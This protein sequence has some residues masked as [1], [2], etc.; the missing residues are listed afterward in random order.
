MDAEILKEK[1]KNKETIYV[2]DGGGT[3][4]IPLTEGV[5]VGQELYVKFCKHS[6]CFKLSNVFDS[7]EEAEEHIKFGNITREDS[8]KLPTWKEINRSPKQSVEFYVLERGEFI[9]Y[10]MARNLKEK[11]IVITMYSWGEFAGDVIFEE[12]FNQENY[13]IARQLFVELFK[14][15]EDEDERY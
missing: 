7:L 3:W 13:T 5:V 4:E 12:P 6:R 14:G 9:N 15:E 1:I 10:A 8:L 2:V 11:T